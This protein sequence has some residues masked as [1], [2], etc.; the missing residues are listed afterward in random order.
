MCK[1]YSEITSVQ[2]TGR[3]YRGLFEIVSG[4]RIGDTLKYSVYSG[5]ECIMY[6]GYSAIKCFL[7]LTRKYTV[8]KI[9]G[10][11]FGGSSL[12]Y[13]KYTVYR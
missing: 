7:I 6:T 11:L 4:Q 10:F 12:K 2:C 8:L 3:V 13:T 9:Y 1:G 5:C